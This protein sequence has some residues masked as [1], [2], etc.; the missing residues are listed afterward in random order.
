MTFFYSIHLLI[1]SFQKKVTKINFVYTSLTIEIFFI[2]TIVINY[3][4]TIKVVKMFITRQLVVM[5]NIYMYFKMT[6]NSNDTYD[7]SQFQIN[8]M[9]IKSL[10]ICMG[11]CLCQKKLAYIARLLLDITYSAFFIIIAFTRQLKI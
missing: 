4:L 5:Y 10:F 9:K 7:V 8:F 6:V 1:I 2:S 3:T 11:T